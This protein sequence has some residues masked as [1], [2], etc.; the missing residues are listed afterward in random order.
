MTMLALSLVSIPGGRFVL[1]LWLAILGPL[2]VASF[3]L[4]P[5]MHGTAAEHSRQP[6][7]LV[8]VSS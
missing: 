6:E 1:F 7:V 3:P 2:S 4:H 5:P 8:N